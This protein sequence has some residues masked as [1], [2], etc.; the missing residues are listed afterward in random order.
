[1]RTRDKVIFNSLSFLEYSVKKAR[2]E[3]FS[4]ITNTIYT[5]LKS[6]EY[7]SSKLLTEK[8]LF[9]RTRVSL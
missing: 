4:I 1:M 5:S 6:E 9:L 8:N 2:E 7:T 3:L